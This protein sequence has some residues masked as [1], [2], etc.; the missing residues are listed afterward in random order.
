MEKYT[1]YDQVHMDTG[2]L[3]ELARE[4]PEDLESFSIADFSGYFGHEQN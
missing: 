3:E 1:E 4:L 2:K